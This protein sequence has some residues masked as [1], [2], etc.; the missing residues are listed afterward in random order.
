MIISHK[1]PTIEKSLDNITKKIN[2]KR[3]YYDNLERVIVK[4]TIK[5]RDAIEKKHRDSLL[6][7]KLYYASKIGL[8][9]KGGT[10]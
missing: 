2:L 4:K 8:Q 7:R 5:R 3:D 9:S 1:V 10:T 6:R